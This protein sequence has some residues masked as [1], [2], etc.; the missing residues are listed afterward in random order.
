MSAILLSA[1]VIAAILA[2][3]PI[4]VAAS[5]FPRYARALHGPDASAPAAAAVLHRICRAYAAVGLAVPVLGFATAVSMG[6]LTDAWVLVSIALTA[7]AV[8]VLIAAILPAQRAALDG[9]TVTTLA[10]TTGVFNLLW[11]VVT[12]LMIV[13]PGSSTG[14]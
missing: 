10:M 14:V 6:V 7:V 8:V 5:M 9:A 3:G 13:R 2:V 12:V 1:H 4:A 11:V